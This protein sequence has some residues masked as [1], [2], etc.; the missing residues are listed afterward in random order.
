MNP[1]LTAL[2]A[3]GLLAVLVAW[4]TPNR[5]ARVALLV[6]AVTAGAAAV[7]LANR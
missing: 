4:R 1:T 6:L 7:V 3:A 2:V 5:P